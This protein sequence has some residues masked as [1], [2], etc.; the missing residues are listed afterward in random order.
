M[1]K[2]SSFTKENFLQTDFAVILSLNKEKKY[3]GGIINT[4]NYSRNTV[5]T[6]LKRLLKSNKIYRE[7]GE[8]GKYIYSISDRLNINDVQYDILDYLMYNHKKLMTPN[9]CRI[10]C[11]LLDDGK[12][13]IQELISRGWKPAAIYKNTKKLE[14]NQIIVK[15]EEG[16]YYRF[17]STVKEAATNKG[18]KLSIITYN[19]DDY[20]RS[21]N[22]KEKRIDEFKK[23][24]D[25]VSIISIQDFKVGKDKKW[26]EKLAGDNHKIILPNKYEEDNHNYMIIMLLVNN[27]IFKNYESLVLGEDSLF[28]LR[29]TYG[30]LTLK[31]GKIIRVLNLYVPQSFNIDEKRKLDIKNFWRIIIKEVRRCR[32]INEEFI[33]LGD[34]NAFDDEK[35]KNRDS[36]LRLKDIMVDVCKEKIEDNPEWG[37]TW[38][39]KDGKTKR[40]LDYIFVNSKILYNNIL[41]CN[42]D[43]SP[44]EKNISDH[45]ILQLIINATTRNKDGEFK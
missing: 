9:A 11:V 20:C 25:G 38:I 45:K 2:L 10:M 18:K 7:K 37:D 39:S 43:S 3:L 26:A 41:A 31:N 19:F 17:S 12:Y 16:D 42:V 36:F 27:E 28:N 15:D 6:V 14:E 30:R 24:T 35:S 5:N 44:L 29:Y 21:E 33:V 23:I 4:T 40:R 34:L 8:A 32:K 22:D 13:S 1:K